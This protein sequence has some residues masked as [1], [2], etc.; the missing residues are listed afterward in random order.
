MALSLWKM[1]IREKDDI[2]VSVER[3]S[4]KKSRKALRVVLETGEDFEPLL[5]EQAEQIIGA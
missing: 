5:K 1:I 3:E 4:L 2:E